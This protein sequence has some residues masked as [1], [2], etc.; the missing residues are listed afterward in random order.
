MRDVAASGTDI[1]EIRQG[2][3]VVLQVADTG[4]GMDEATRAR[5]FEP[6]FTTKDLE[7]GSGLGLATVQSIVKK[8]GGSIRVESSP[9]KGARFWI[10]LPSVDLQ[11]TSQL[12]GTTN[13]ESP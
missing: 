13:P 12:K 11:Q 5:I 2:R 6:L 4:D 7:K 8:L 9:G 10:Y 1:A 3:Y